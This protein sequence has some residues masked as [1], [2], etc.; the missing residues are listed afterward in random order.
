M[1]I[2]ESEY[3]TYQE[4]PVEYIRMQVDQSNPFYVKRQVKQLIRGI[5]CMDVPE[6]R[7]QEFFQ[8]FLVKLA[9]SFDQYQTGQLPDFRVKEAT[10]HLLGMMA[11]KFMKCKAVGEYLEPLLQKQVFPELSSDNAFLRLRASQVYGRFGDLEFKDV[12]HLRYVLN[13][14]YQNLNH[15]ELPVR[16]EAAISFKH[17]LGHEE[18]VN[19]LKPGLADV[20]KVYLKIMDDIDFDD[21]VSALQAVVTVFEDEIAPFAQGL[22]QKLGE[23]FIRLI[24]N[25]GSGDEED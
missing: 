14:L 17:L 15:T 10:M 4:N 19:F 2:S 16:V 9:N 1:M 13:A 25:K 20:L 6:Q 21:L 8:G 24:N 18:A 3:Y 7:Q 5:C 12:D 23:A 11:D 22:C